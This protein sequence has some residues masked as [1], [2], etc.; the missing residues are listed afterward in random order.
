MNNQKDYENIYYMPK[1]SAL[2]YKITG[3]YTNPNHW[4]EYVEIHYFFDT[5]AKIF[6][7]DEVYE[8]TVG[9]L[10]IINRNQM[11]TNEGAGAFLFHIDLPEF[12]GRHIPETFMFH[13]FIR[14]DETINE[15]YQ[16]ILREYKTQQEGYETV[17]KGYTHLLIA[18]LMRNYKKNAVESN[19]Y[20][21]TKNK[22]QLIEMITTYI[23]KNYFAPI[24]TSSIAETFHLSK[25]Y[26]CSFFKTQTGQSVTSYINKCRVDKA[27]ILLENTDNNIIEIASSVG[28]D[29][30]N[31][32]SRIFKQYMKMTPKEYRKSK[33]K[34]E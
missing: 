13:N 6:C 9:D 28:Y 27:A 16:H 1:S 24:K 3:A 26:L 22:A 18:H 15:I 10:V 29:D 31:Y 21:R 5:S 30:S 25:Q 20:F 33:I 19:N 17:I 34:T 14:N 23:N 7:D 4:H 2:K 11:H 8:A 32:F 12:L